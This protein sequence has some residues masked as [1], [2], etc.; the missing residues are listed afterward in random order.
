MKVPDSK[1]MSGKQIMLFERQEYQENCVSNII[2]VLDSSDNL[3]DFSSLQ[4][5]V[6]KIQQEKNINVKNISDEPRLDILMETGT[7]KTF[8]YLKT[9]YEMNKRYGINKFVIFVPRIAI[10][11]GIVQNIDLTADYFFQEYGKR[12]K[13]HTY[14]GKSG[15]N[16]VDDYIRNDREFSVLILT[17]ASILAKNKTDRHLTNPQDAQLYN[18]QSPLE[19]IKELGP[20]VFIDEP[21]LLKGEKFS[22]TYKKYFSNSLLLRFGATFPDE[23]ENKLSNVVYALDSIHA[24]RDNLVKKISVTTIIDHAS[25]IKF[26]HS[27]NKLK[28]IKISYFKNGVEYNSNIATE[29]NISTVTGDKNHDFH[30]IRKKGDEIFLSN[31]ERR[32]MSSST[33]TLTDNT[34]REMIK[35]TINLHFEKEERLFLQG[36][37]TLSLFFIPTVADF[38]GENPRI[39]KMFED[40]Y[41]KQYRKILVKS[42]DPAYREYL[43]KDYNAN[44]ALSVHEGYFSGDKGS[45]DTKESYGVNLILNDKPKLLST[46]EPLRFIF[47]VWA[48]Q[49][50]WDNPN[51]FTLCKLAS[52]DKE[53]KRKQQVGRGLRLAVDNSGQRWTI[54]R[55]QD[56]EDIFYRVNELDVVVPG[57]EQNFI[58]GLQNEIIGSSITSNILTREALI[59]L[60]LSGSQAN[61]FIIF[62]EDNDVVS[63]TDRTDMYNIHTPINDFLEKNRDILP[64]ELVE[65]YNALLEEFR[66]VNYFSINNKNS[67]LDKIGIRIEKFKEFEALW[68]TITSKAKIVYKSIDDNELIKSIKI[69]F[70]KEKIRPLEMKVVKKTY[71]HT[72]NQITHDS[73]VCLGDVVFFEID[74]YAKFITDFSCRENLPLSFCRKMF[75]TLDKNKIKNN[76]RKAYDLLSEIVKQEIHNNIIQSIGYEFD[77]NIM[78]NARNSRDIFYYDQAHTKPKIKIESTKIGKYPSKD[79]I[80]DRHYLYDKLMFDSKIELEVMTDDPREINEDSKVTVFAKLPKINIPTPYKSYNPDFAYY[81]QNKSGKKL[82]LV[83]ETKGYNREVDIPDD[84][85]RKIKY[86]EKFFEALNKQTKIA[87]VVYKKR[88]NRDEL[89]QLLSDIKWE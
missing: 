50:G 61:R 80:P 43:K 16:Q 39:K 66:H 62:L 84:E 87:E 14:G 52:T 22:T 15:L 70:D 29:D 48:L 49:E 78:I 69:A 58:E 33:Y 54:R 67:P 6:K 55:C 7:G 60:G 21:H 24:F 44:G 40:E 28:P 72:T 20:V 45:K 59:D 26:H 73:E 89:S 11:A 56:S 81:I 46:K 47:S 35:K 82:F 18:M 71:D 79:H 31:N 12:I 9:M 2:E 75:N 85:K 27:K 68:K 51:I 77:G 1:P 30:V 65:K 32:N 17:S 88:I 53:I 76:P 19:V 83:V 57:H 42:I 74:G 86:A 25:S 64:Q 5:N 8:T 4:E 3:S 34:I 41:K 63:A 36:T 38:R 37:K 23:E 13:K 10:R